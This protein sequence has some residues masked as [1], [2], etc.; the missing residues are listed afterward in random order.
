MWG[1]CVHPVGSLQTTQAAAEDCARGCDEYIP[2]PMLVYVATA[3]FLCPAW[4][5]RP[6]IG[7]LLLGVVLV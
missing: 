5:L 4:V 2:K 7:C 3:L 1:L 6:Y